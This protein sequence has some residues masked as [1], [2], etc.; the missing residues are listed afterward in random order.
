MTILTRWLT[1]AGIFRNDPPKSP[2]GNG[3]K[4]DGDNGSGGDSGGSGP[5]N[6]WSFPP[7]GKRGRP[8]GGGGGSFDD[9]FRR[10]RR[11]GGGIPGLPNG[12][13]LWYLAG[14]ALL[15]VWLITCFHAI[16]PQ[17]RGVV[18]FLGTYSRT[19]DSGIQ[20]TLPWPINTVETVD[21]QNI[22]KEDFP[23]EG[24]ENL[25]ITGDQNV[26]NLAY[27]VRWDIRSP[28]DYVFQIKEQQDT[29]R[30]TAESAMRAVVANVTLNQ[31]IGDGRSRIEAQVQAAMQ[32]VLDEYHSGIRIQGVAIQKAGA[33]DAV[34]E[35][36]KKVTA[37]QQ[38]A[39]G[40]KNSAR[41]YAQQVIANAQGQAAQF[42]KIYE[43]YKAAPEVTRRRI[44]Y[45]TME[46]V[47]QKSDKVIVEA[48][49]VT[50]YLP[51]PAIRPGATPAPRAEGAK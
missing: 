7:E 44:Y 22:R 1:S 23:K 25:M 18:R 28:S 6:P 13:A 43:Q 31:A 9:L 33:P 34:D 30:D 11:G 51:L 15:L 29:V 21:V 42:D 41:G 32:Q 26:V 8:G 19:L 20:L 35:A 38:R 40:L 50:P 47:L 46:Q 12:P 2:W 49:G 16:A 10:A 3:G 45:E 4:G 48:P 24:G 27:S 5:R 17:E 14:G 39:E 36:F 37:A